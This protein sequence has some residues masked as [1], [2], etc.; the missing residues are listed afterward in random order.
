MNDS[1][2]EIRQLLQE[3]VGHL[4]AGTDAEKRRAVTKLRRIAAI[5]STMVLT[6]Q[7]QR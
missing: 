1:I 5:A 2:G 4:E 6:L 7:M 3:I